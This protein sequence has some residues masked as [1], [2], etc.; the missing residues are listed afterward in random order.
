MANTN[1]SRGS[2]SSGD[3]GCANS[4]CSSGYKWVRA[5]MKGVCGGTN[6]HEASAG[7]Q[8]SAGGYKQAGRRDTN[9]HGGV[10]TQQGQQQG[11]CAPHPS[12]PSPPTN[13]YFYLL[14]KMFWHILCIYLQYLMKSNC[15]YHGYHSFHVIPHNLQDG[16]RYGVGKPKLQ[17]TCSKHYF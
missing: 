3:S 16:Y 13:F 5:G 12:S 7:V 1:T 14:F 9:E 6:K 8:I 2:G 10:W 11:L 15:G 4:K 17:V